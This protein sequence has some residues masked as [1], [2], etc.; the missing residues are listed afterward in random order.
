MANVLLIINLKAGRFK[1]KAV[2]YDCVVPFCEAGDRVT[3]AVTDRAG[4]ATD[5]ARESGGYDKIVCCGG[6][7][8][9]NEVVQ[10]I[11]G[12]DRKI[13]IGYIPAGSTNDF[14]NSI[15]LE[16]DTRKAVDAIVRGV[17]H[18]LD[19]GSFNGRYFTYIASFGAFTAASYNTS[20]NMKNALGHLAYILEGMKELS[21]MQTCFVR[22]VSPDAEY[23][24]E[25]IF[26][27]VSNTISM[28]GLVKLSTEF[29]DMNDGLLEVLLVKAPKNLSEL[30]QILLGIANSDFSGEMFTFFKSPK[31]TICSDGSFSWSLDGEKAEGCEKVEIQ[32]IPDAIEII[33]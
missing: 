32:A 12:A 26:G 24:G 23:D 7:G 15:S 1:S 33:K 18:T 2:L 31:V 3:V 9:L 8:T 17:P 25:Y 16:A 10:G 19:V 28:G 14:A 30:N 29:V 27:S 20:Q 4:H 21:K 11:M 6:D 5:L 13:P 22:V